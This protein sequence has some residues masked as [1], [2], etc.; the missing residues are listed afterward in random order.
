MLQ[1]VRVNNVEINGKVEKSWNRIYKESNGN[2][3][4]KKYNNKLRNWIDGLHSRIEITKEI[5][6]FEDRVI[7]IVQSEKWREN[8]WKN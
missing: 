6:E 1:Q 4:T 2:S 8:D 3:K 5:S 7:E